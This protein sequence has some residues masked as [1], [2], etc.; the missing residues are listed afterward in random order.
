M[1]FTNIGF[2]SFNSKY[3]KELKSGAITCSMTVSDKNAD[4]EYETG[5]IN[6]LIPKKCITPLIK[7]ALKQSSKKEKSPLLNISG[8]IKMNGKYADAFIFEA[9]EYT[10][11]DPDQ[12]PF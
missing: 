3:D 6:C 2:L 5:Y 11:D 1:N 9:K 12:L 8:V 7:K 4:G 10:K